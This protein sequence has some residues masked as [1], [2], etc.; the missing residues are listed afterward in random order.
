MILVTGEHTYFG[1]AEEAVAL[2]GYHIVGEVADESGQQA[3]E[4][5][6]GGPRNG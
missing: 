5:C 2:A 1:A 6:G 4:E 3:Q